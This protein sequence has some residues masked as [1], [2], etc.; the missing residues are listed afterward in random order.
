MSMTPTTGSALR[1]SRYLVV[2]AGELAL[3]TYIPEGVRKCL[4]WVAEYS[5][6]GVRELSARQRR[7]AGAVEGFPRTG[8]LVMGSR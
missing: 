2:R 7:L 3:D 8:R 1:P 6:Q 4:N 5:R